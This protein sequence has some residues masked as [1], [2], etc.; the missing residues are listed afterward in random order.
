MLVRLLLECSTTVLKNVCVCLCVC[1][2]ERVRADEMTSVMFLCMQRT[3]MTQLTVCFSTI[4]MRV[5]VG[6]CVCECSDHP[7][8][9][10][11]WRFLE[12]IG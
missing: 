5:I 12:V 7:A 4:H 11:L 9:R 1:E 3:S 8:G 6:V 2:R 10:G